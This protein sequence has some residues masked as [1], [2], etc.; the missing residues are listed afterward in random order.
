M[1]LRGL[2]SA[3]RESGVLARTEEG[4]QL[5]GALRADRQLQDL[6][7][8]R[9][10]SFAPEELE[11]VEV[12]AAAEVLDWEILRGLCDA[13]AV[14]SLERRGV[15]QLIVDG[16]QTVA[17]LFHPVLGEVACNALGWCA[18]GSS[19]A[20]WHNIFGSTCRRKSSARG[21][22]TCAPRSSWP[23]S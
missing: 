22:P 2:L 6:L 18:R 12:L 8:F 7:E 20:C 5:R 11:A 4:W 16:S 19:M 23:S 3:G 13:D 17:R 9:L 15:V 10:R 14:V 1:L 21:H